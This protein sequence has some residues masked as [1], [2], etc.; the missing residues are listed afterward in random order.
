MNMLISAAAAGA[1]VLSIG[2]AAPTRANDA[3]AVIAS[4]YGCNE[5]LQSYTFKMDVAMAMRHFPWFHFHL[6]GEGIYERGIR[7]EVHFTSMPGF[8][9]RMPRDIDLSMIDPSMW[10]KRY[11]YYEIAQREGDTIFALQSLPA[12]AQSL[13]AATIALNPTFGAHWVDAEYSDGTHIH[14]NVSSNLIEGFLLPEALTASVDYPHM[15][16]SANADFMQYQ[17]P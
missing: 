2:I 13:K 17:L 15:P 4:A 1:L 16:L 14:M 11:R 3:P 6:K 12:E 8:A 9:S 5:A 7:Y 10:P